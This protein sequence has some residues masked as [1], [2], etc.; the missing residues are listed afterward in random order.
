MM[1]NSTATT[2]TP[3]QTSRHSVFLRGFLV[4]ASNP[5]ALLFFAAF[6]PQ[7]LN[8]TLPFAPQFGI[9]SLTFVAFEMTVL[10]VCA[11]EI[12]HIAPLMGTLLLFTR[13]HA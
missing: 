12:S 6:F 9:L 3:A 5:K 8:P 10:T 1:E 7:F 11:L 4:G 2:K 13:R